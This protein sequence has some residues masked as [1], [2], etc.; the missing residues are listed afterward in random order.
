MENKGSAGIVVLAVVIL[1]F[2]VLYLILRL[3]INA[4]NYNFQGVLTYIIFPTSYI[5]SAIGLLMLK[6]WGRLLAIITAS[7]ALLTLL[8]G[9]V[10]TFIIKHPIGFSYPILL[11]FLFP[12]IIIYYLTRPTIKER[13]K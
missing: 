7:M 4:V 1:F 5:I 3:F 2:A 11:G 9:I 6:N 10:F 13:F 12:L 8:F